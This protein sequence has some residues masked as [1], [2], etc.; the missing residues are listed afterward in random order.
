LILK[1]AHINS[2]EGTDYTGTSVPKVDAKKN[3][4]LYRKYHQ[5]VL[6][7]VV[8]SAIA[9]DMGGLGIGLL[10]SAIGGQLGVHV[11]IK[12]V[13]QSSLSNSERLFSESN[14]R[15]L[16]SVHS[17]QQT[18]FEKI[19]KGCSM[20]KIGVVTNDNSII[21]DNGKKKVASLRVTDATTAYRHKFRD[22]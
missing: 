4:A 22:S 1:I 15:L 21:I 9:L 13:G 8:A 7:D 19:M 3:L 10:K 17:S 12:T 20:A 11:D 18:Q 5:A 2:K 14:G 6:K 16:V